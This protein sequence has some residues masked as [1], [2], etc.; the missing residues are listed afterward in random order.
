M[1]D[2]EEAIQKL[3]KILSG[4]LQNK[5]VLTV[6]Q[7][8]KRRIFELGLDSND[9]RIGT[10]SDSYVKQRINKKLG[11]DRKV[12]LEFTGQMRRDFVPKKEKGVIVESSFTN[13]ANDKKAG[14]VE[15]TYDKD[16]F[17]LT[18]KEKKLLDELIQ[19]EIE[20]L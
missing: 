9:R 16:I 3:N 20:K 18:P 15:E 10:Y 12:T 14:Y 1:N 8:V 4:E 19:I 7:Q 11:S 6:H 17:E 2:I 13:D 5:A